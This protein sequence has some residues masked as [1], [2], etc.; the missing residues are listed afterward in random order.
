MASTPDVLERVSRT[1]GRVAARKRVVTIALALAALLAFC[2]S[3]SVGDF[4]ISVL[5]VLPAVFGAGERGEVFVVQSLRLPRALLSVL[6]GAAFGMSGA[7]FQ[8]LAR[9]PLA[10]PDILGITAGGSLT[11]VMGLTLLGLS[12][13]PLSLAAT[14]GALIT[15]GLIY[16]FA[17]RRGMSSYRLVLVGIGV[18]A[19]ATALTQFFWTRAHAHD[20][21][22]VALWLSGSLNGRGWENI[23][24]VVLM[25]LVLIPGTLALGKQLNVLEL[26]DDSATAVGVPVQRARLVL[27]IAGVALAGAGIGAAGPVA[28]VAFVS[29]PVARRL[30]RS[31][32]PA[33][34]PAALTGSVLVCV[35]D[36]IGRT[37]L[38]SSEVSVGVITGIAGAPYL[39]WLLATTNS[40]GQGD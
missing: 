6:V 29:A 23:E 33:L 40:S 30:S 9:N 21:A 15:A 36:L 1:R 11:A 39:L 7:V 35:A 17:Y 12:G 16:T 14:A 10:S 4:T 25:L 26:G 8:S 37:A 32:G 27:L 28:F 24:P 13:L 31:P 5:R 38:S 18:G 3:L 19:V 20:A 34:L 22:S 2:L